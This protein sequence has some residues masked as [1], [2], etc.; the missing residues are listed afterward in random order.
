[1][2]GTNGDIWLTA[3][4]PK[5]GDIPG[6]SSDPEFLLAATIDGIFIVLLVQTIGTTGG[7]KSILTVSQ[8]EFRAECNCQIMIGQTEWQFNCRKIC[9]RKLILKRPPVKTV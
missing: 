8:R 2:G 3:N 6:I 1:M 4:E 5:D 7:D 9:H